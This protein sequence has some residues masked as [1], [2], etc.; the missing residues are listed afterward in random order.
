MAAVDFTRCIFTI[1]PISGYIRTFYNF[2]W[3]YITIVL[4]GIAA[5]ILL[6]LARDTHITAKPASVT[7][8]TLTALK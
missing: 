5:K 7:L 4:S 3:S 8:I 2:S 6:D 1:S